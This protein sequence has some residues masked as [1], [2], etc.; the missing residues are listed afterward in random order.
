MTKDLSLLKNFE[1]T[2]GYKVH[3]D[4]YIVSIKLGKEEVLKGSLDSKGYLYLDIR[5]S[6]AEIKCPKIHRLVAL[7]FVPNPKNKPQ[8]NHIDGN[9][10]NNHYSN[11]QWVTNEE[12]RTHAIKT[13][14]KNEIHYGIAQYDL[15]GNL[16]NVFKT[17]TEALA[18]LGIANPRNRAGE[19]GRVIRGK[20]KTA[21]GFIW[22]QHEGSTTNTTTQ[23]NG[24]G[25]REP[26]KGE[27][28]V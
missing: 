18:S 12:N 9:K 16:L 21:F 24:V 3:S 1:K 15:N 20:R 5:H 8:V 13:G 2:S 28:I 22:K 6:G 26:R 25:N 27:D 10:T 14:L 17:A 19:V 11:L 23:A 4:G 7:A